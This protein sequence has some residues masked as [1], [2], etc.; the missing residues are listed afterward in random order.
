MRNQ[1]HW[2]VQMVDMAGGYH[3]FDRAMLASV[4][5]GGGS[6][7][8]SDYDKRLS[9]DG[10]RDLMAFLTRQGSRPNAPAKAE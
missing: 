4:K 1:D 6:V 2:S 9:P 5:V 3:S 10:F 8:P 7:M